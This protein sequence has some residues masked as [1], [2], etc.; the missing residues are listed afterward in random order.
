MLH[1]P[2][3]YP[4]PEVFRPERFLTEDGQVKDDPAL[5]AVFGFGKRICPGRYLV[6]STIFIFVTSALSV[7]TVGKAK[8]T[9]GNEIPVNVASTSALVR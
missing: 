7:F 4:D 9:Q 2:D 8:D 6:D 5:S 3:V 1:D